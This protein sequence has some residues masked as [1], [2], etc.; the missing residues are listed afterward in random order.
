MTKLRL[1]CAD[2]VLVSAD[3]HQAAL[4][5]TVASILEMNGVDDDLPIKLPLVH[6]THLNCVLSLLPAKAASPDSCRN[7]AQKL[8]HYSLHELLGLALA[9]NYLDVPALADATALAIA[10]VMRDL[11]SSDLEVLFHAGSGSSE[12][13]TIVWPNDLPDDVFI[14]V[15]QHLGVQDGQQ[16]LDRCSSVSPAWRRGASAR[17]KVYCQTWARQR[18]LH[19]LATFDGFRLFGKHVPDMIKARLAC[20]PEAQEELRTTDPGAGWTPLHHAA[21]HCT[22]LRAGEI[23]PGARRAQSGPTC[24]GYPADRSAPEGVRGLGCSVSIVRTLVE[25]YP[26][27]RRIESRSVHL[28]STPVELARKVDASPEVLT[29]LVAG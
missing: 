7:C 13:E 21:Y 9:I 6:S 12:Q 3:L 14:P 28:G 11:R 8:S 24:I 23:R 22:A 19:Q 15:L 25:A 4:L 1:L 10:T 17:L 18:T 26:E 5:G 29:L 2:G 27:A 16:F 20:C